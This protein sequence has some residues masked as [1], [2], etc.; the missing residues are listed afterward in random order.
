MSSAQERTLAQYHGLMQVNASSHLLRSARNLGVLK[1]LREGQ[2]TRTQLAESLSLV[3]DRLSLLIE[4][5]M[6]IGIVESYGDDLA[7]SRAGHLLCQYDEDFGDGVW[8]TLESLVR[9]EVQREASDDLMQSNYLAATQWIHTSS[10]MQAA[11]ILDVGGESMP[12]GI[13]ILDLG[14]GSGVWGAAMAYRDEESHLTVADL[15]SAVASAKATAESIGLTDRFTTIEGD[16]DEVAIESG[17]FDLSLVAQRLSARADEPAVSLIARAA[18]A[19]KPGGQVVVIDLFRGK[20]NLNLSDSIEALRLDLAT[21]AGRMRTLQEGQAIMAA[22]G[23][24]DVQFTYLPDS[25]TQLGMLVG[26]KA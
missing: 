17:A 19:T 20:S 16:P 2:R 6:A 21:R 24:G 18:E 3:P 14:C 1:E 12:K 26:R 9:G 10:A 23:L 7:L 13:S 15:P 5:L 22:A 8:Q 4:A 25:R 11:E